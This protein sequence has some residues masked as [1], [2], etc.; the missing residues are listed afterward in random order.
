MRRWISED[1]T[2]ADSAR[3][4]AQMVRPPLSR[5]E[6]AEKNRSLIAGD[7]SLA[8]GEV[9]AWERGRDWL[10]RTVVGDDPPPGRRRWPRRRISLPAH[11]AGVGDAFTDDI[12][13][14]GMALRSPRPSAFRPGEEASVRLNL[15][16]R[17]IY[18]LGKVVWTTAARVGL[19]I[20]AI[21]PADQRALE[22]TVCDGLLEQWR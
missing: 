16:G 19:A 1:W 10:C 20:V 7:R 8:E 17:S 4:M 12:G 11:I 6:F 15:G 2:T 22:A 9:A 5:D 3:T 18:A 14:A 21:H 13:F